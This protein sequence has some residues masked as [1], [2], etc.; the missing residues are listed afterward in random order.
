MERDDISLEKSINF[1]KIKKYDL[2][3]MRLYCMPNRVICKTLQTVRL[4]ET[5]LIIETLEYRHT[6]VDLVI[7]MW[8]LM[9]LTVHKSNTNSQRCMIHWR[10]VS[11][12]PLFGFTCFIL[13]SILKLK[14]KM[15][16]PLTT[17]P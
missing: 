16:Q 9:H 14:R 8:I 2:F 10:E 12:K 15:K 13:R 6:E 17:I 11:V 7:V 4:K 3:G 1:T 5:C